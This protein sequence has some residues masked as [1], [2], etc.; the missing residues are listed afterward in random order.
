MF[1]EL[2]AMAASPS[3]PPRAHC[4][5]RRLAQYFADKR[6]KV[7]L[8]E[9]RAEQERRLQAGEEHSVKEEEPQPEL[10]W[11]HPD[12]QRCMWPYASARRRE[13]RI[14]MISRTLHTKGGGYWADEMSAENAKILSSYTAALPVAS[15]PSVSR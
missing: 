11:A 10:Q 9:R 12:L 1:C 8:E 2:L 7:R 13:V 5:G 3:Q 15:K 4:A 14:K 6:A